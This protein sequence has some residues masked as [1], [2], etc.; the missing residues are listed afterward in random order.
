M[1]GIAGLVGS[2]DKSVANDTVARMMSSLARRGPDDHGTHSWE[3]AVL[4]HRRLAIFD[5]SSAGRQP[6]LSPDGRIGIVFNGSIYNYRS[7]RSDLISRG[8]TFLSDTDTE[9]LV[10]GY[11]EWGLDELLRRLRGMFAFALWD[12]TRHRLFLV[13]DRLGVKPLSYIVRGDTI[14]FA[15]T[16]RALSRGGLASDL[17]PRGILAYLGLSYVPD[18]MSVYRSVK[19]VPAATLIEWNDGIISERCYWRAPVPSDDV[20]TSFDDAVDKAEHLLLEAVRSRLYA[21]VPT[22]ALLSGGVDSG[23]VC[24]AISQLNRN[25]TVFTVGVPGDPWDETE[26][27]RHTAQVLGV[28]HEVLDLSGQDDVEPERL[29]AAYAEP[30]AAP[31]GLG[32]LKVSEAVS[33]RVTVLL[34]GDGGDDM[35]LGYPRHRHL[36]TAGKLPLW[37]QPALRTGWRHLELLFPRK[38]PLRRMAALFDYASGN[39][40]AYFNH[41]AWLSNPLLNP[42]LGPRLNDLQMDTASP[43]VPGDQSPLTSVLAY[44][45]ES[46]FVGEYLTKVDGATMHYALEARSP[47]LDQELWE[48][49][50]SLPYDI[51]LRHGML[52]AVLRTIV[53]R[54]ID[55]TTAHRRKSGFSIPVHRWIRGKWRR[56]VQSAFEDSVLQREGWIDTTYAIQLLEQPDLPRTYLDQLWYLYVLELWMR[57][58]RSYDASVV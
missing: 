24:W 8:C 21:H 34:T 44:E 32:M 30:F 45:I 46:R 17:D 35:F 28:K 16:P 12:D 36:W 56:R 13:R 20:V 15:S 54:R 2:K 9:V 58:E 29:T 55:P 42:L 51:R 43:T 22:G 23:L 7:L 33:G 6:M 50:A 5:L 1:C 19:K 57:Q 25:L 53:K 11:I 3:D 40:D 37:A 39:L 31:S 18:Q 27:A 26:A 4:G 48:F 41:W 38:G 49:A 52:K 10:L 14:G 47:F